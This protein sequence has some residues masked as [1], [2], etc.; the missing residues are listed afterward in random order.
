MTVVA[1]TMAKDEID[2]AEGFLQ[3]LAAEVDHIVVADNGSTDG[4]RELLEALT[5]ELPMVVVDDPEVGYYQS[6]KMTGLARLAAE[7]FGPDGLII[8]P[9]D[10]DELWHSR[11]GRLRDVLPRDEGLVWRAS[12]FNH[13]RTS[14]DVEDPDPFRSMTWRQ[15]QP[16][17]LPKVAFRW[18]AEAVIEQGNHDVYLPRWLPGQT[19]VEVRHFPVRSADHLVRKARNGSRAYTAAP[20]LPETMGN[21]WRSWGRILDTMGEDALREAYHAHWWY[22]S[23]VDAGLIDDPAPYRRDDQ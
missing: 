20:D 2:V 3:H 14:L 23:P 7:K 18:C 10:F 6:A 5:L 11:A 12:L 4:T 9:V 17:M 22:L 13:L 19:H 15:R 8:V 1:V 21:H 16:G